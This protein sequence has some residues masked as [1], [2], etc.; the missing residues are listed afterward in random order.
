L[1]SVYLLPSPLEVFSRSLLIIILL[2]SSILRILKA[3]YKRDLLFSPEKSL[4]QYISS[5]LFKSGDTAA[6]D[7]GGA[8]DNDDY[9]DGEYI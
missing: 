8:D 4:L 2:F 6:P 7:A 9:D 5:P 1:K 3:F